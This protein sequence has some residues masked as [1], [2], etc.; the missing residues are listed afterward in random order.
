MR[1]RSEDGTG[2]GLRLSIVIP[3]YNGRELLAGCLASVM[4]HRPADSE[5][6]VVDD[7]S[8]DG[9]REWLSA[10][11]PE[12]RLVTLERNQGFCKAI[13][14]GIRAAQAP[15]VETLN[16]D[17]V[18][19]AGWADAALALFADPRVGSVAPLVWLKD[20]DGLIDSAGDQYHVC[21]WAMNRGHRKPIDPDLCRVKEVFGAS[22]SAAFFRRE[23]LERVGAFPE[24][25]GAYYD[26][27]HLAFR[28]RHAGYRCLYTPHA[29]VFH[30][31]H[32]SYDHGT[33]RV[34]AQLS[35]NEE[36][37]FW[38][39]L[40]AAVLRRAALP[41]FVYVA[42]NAF[43]RLLHGQ[44]GLAYL[45]GKWLAL[46]EV[47]ALRRARQERRE[48]TRQ[49]ASP[50][51]LPLETD[52]GLLLH[53]IW[54]SA[55]A[56]LNR[57]RWVAAHVFAAPF[58]VRGFASRVLGLGRPKRPFVSSSRLKSGSGETM[59]ETRARAA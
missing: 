57:L 52:A 28:L 10:A 20:E 26:D 39:N 6:I 30:R 4:R 2:G 59:K 24:Y 7:G 1:P 51:S 49:A 37:V 44:H 19:T 56:L 3:T 29:H 54:G 11:H 23:A 50:V 36:R 9:T 34:V 21:G 5:V 16:N 58:R 15:F 41:H 27:I 43:G 22:A 55:L 48:L 31:L 53:R 18:V 40:P 14:A 47:S 17:A 42:C 32:A 35:L 46:R 13:N 12:V 8:S 33:A 38:A 25:F 45:R